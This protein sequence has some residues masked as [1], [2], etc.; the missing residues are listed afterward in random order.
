MLQPRRPHANGAC[1]CPIQGLACKAESFLRSKKGGDNIF[2]Y[3]T[4]DI[5]MH[6]KAVTGDSLTD[7]KDMIRLTGGTRVRYSELC[8]RAVL[9]FETCF[10]FRD[11]PP[12]E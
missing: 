11:H 2:K 5:P 6:F 7:D 1:P 8:Q 10:S 9:W 4:N 3:M 12:L